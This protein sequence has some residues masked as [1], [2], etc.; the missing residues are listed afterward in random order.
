MVGILLMFVETDEE[1]QIKICILT[2]FLD[3]FLTNVSKYKA[4]GSV[5]TL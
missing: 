1:I 5:Q 4:C 3:Y 2:Y